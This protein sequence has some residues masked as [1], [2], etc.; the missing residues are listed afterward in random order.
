MA[1]SRP[2]LG[3]RVDRP[4]PETE[5]VP[6]GERQGVSPPSNASAESPIPETSPTVK[7][8]R[9]PGAKN[10]EYVRGE[11]N[12]GMCPKCKCTESKIESTR[13]IPLPND[14]DYKFVALIRC[15]CANKQC[16]QWR[17]DRQKC[18]PAE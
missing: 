3:R 17:V 15:M 11:R 16:G 13:V 14:P 18:N 8:G 10:R 2:Q 12:P 9:P 5:T 7:S 4:Q 1:K 6:A